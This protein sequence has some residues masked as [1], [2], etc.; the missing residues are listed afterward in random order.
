MKRFFYT[1][2]S[3][4]HTKLQMAE[5]ND[6]FK[7]FSSL[8]IHVVFWF[9]FII[10]ETAVGLAFGGNLSPWYDYF[11]YY[12]LNIMLFYIHVAI[13]FKAI[14]Q[15]RINFIRIVTY[16]FLELICYLILKRAFISILNIF[17]IDLSVTKES[18][19]TFLGNSI[20]RAIYFMGLSTAYAY[21]LLTMASKRKIMELDKRALMDQLEMEQLEKN[22]LL[23]ENAFLKAQINPHFLFNTLNVIYDEIAGYSEEAADLLISFSD[24][25]RYA[26]RDS[27][28]NGKV[29][30]ETEIEFIRNYISLNNQRFDKRTNLNL[31]IEGSTSGHKIIPLVLIT[32]VENI[33]KFGEVLDKDYPALV[34]IKLGKNEILIQTSNKISKRPHGY[35]SGIGMKNLIK[36]LDQAYPN[37]YQLHVQNDAEYFNL[38][39]KITV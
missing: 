3:L 2:I 32:I 30:F 21:I 16:I 5:G 8:K 15:D 6:F 12:G 23:T 33:Y 7:K 39:L 13:L 27:D 20:W 1:N 28:E 22:L 11:V 29:D 24:V 4:I 36:R 17:G 9:S 31:T 25:V 35:S 38:H 18:V 34:N 14:S 19:Y 10:Y 37:F 26:F